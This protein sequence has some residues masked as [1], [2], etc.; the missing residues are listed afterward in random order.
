MVRPN[1]LGNC[2]N[3]FFYESINIEGT[4][5]SHWHIAKWMGRI[6]LALEFN[7][8]KRLTVS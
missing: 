3:M 7:E 2:P 8:R 4:Q 1:I 6:S 5:D